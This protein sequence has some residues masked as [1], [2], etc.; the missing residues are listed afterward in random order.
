MARQ[1][2]HAQPRAPDDR[3]RRGRG[4]DYRVFLTV[5]T[6]ITDQALPPDRLCPSFSS[7]KQ[8]KCLAQSNKS[9]RGAYAIKKRDLRIPQTWTAAM[10]K[11]PGDDDRKLC[12][13]WGRARGWSRKRLV[14]MD[15][16]YCE[17]MRA[18]WAT[19]PAA[20]LPPRP[21]VSADQGR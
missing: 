20:T 1:P 15:Q 14:A 21:A 4:Y 10:E 6:V 2:Q 18:A 3:R 19:R 5:V 16:R 12:G 17:A 9:R 11:L 8:D 13:G 7:D